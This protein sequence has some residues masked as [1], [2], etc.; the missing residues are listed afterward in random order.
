[1][2]LIAPFEEARRLLGVSPEDDATAI[3]RAYRRAVLEN[4][5]DRDAEAFR[6]IR[7][8]YELLLD[9]I[10]RA[11]EL[12]LHPLPH[13]P[14]PTLIAPSDAPPPEA[15]VIHLLRRVVARLPA[16]QLSIVPP[17]RRPKRATK[18]ETS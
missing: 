4:P 5:P 7:D 3:K 11:R 9:P 16:Q 8:A 10:P 18:K 13:V 15:A 14:P 2:G 12:L 6:R 17:A 1:M